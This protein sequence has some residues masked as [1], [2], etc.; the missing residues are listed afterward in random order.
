NTFN[1]STGTTVI[2][3]SF[4]TNTLFPGNYTIN[5]T[6][7]DAP[8]GFQYTIAVNS[9]AFLDTVSNSSEIYHN[10]T[11]NG[12][13]QISFKIDN[14]FLLGSLGFHITVISKEHIPQ[15]HSISILQTSI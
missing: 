8:E 13:G 3:G 6:S 11:F 7:Y 10:F 14:R 4:D 15:I 5:V 9:S 12:N 2:N 1:N